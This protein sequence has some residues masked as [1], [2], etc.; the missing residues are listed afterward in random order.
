MVGLRKSSA[1]WG[2]GQHL[3]GLFLA[4]DDFV[5]KRGLRDKMDQGLLDNVVQLVNNVIPL[6]WGEIF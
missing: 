2:R 5:L 1:S 4:L 6:A 3:R